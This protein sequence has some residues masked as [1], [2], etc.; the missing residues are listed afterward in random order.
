MLNND[1]LNVLALVIPTCAKTA[2][3]DEV[4]ALNC[5]FN[6]LNRNPELFVLNG[7]IWYTVVDLVVS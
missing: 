1:Q 6:L 3:C 2:F 7:L 5:A 4:S